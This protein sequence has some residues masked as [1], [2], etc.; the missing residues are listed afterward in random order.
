MKAIERLYQY[1]DNKNIKSTRFEKDLGMSNGYLGIM[2]KRDADLGS[3][4][5]ELIKN[6]CRD[7]NPEWLLT[8]KGNMLTEN[9]EATSAPVVAKS[10][11]KTGEES[12]P[13][14]NIDAVAGFG[15]GTFTLSEKDI[16][17]YYQVPDFNGIDF[18]VRVKGNSMY[19]KYS[20][21]DIIACRIIKE[22]GFIQ[23]NKPHLIATREQGLLVKRLRK[24]D[25]P[26][27]ILAVS[28]N[29][30]YEPFEIPQKEIT[31]I[32]IIIG[33]ISLE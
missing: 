6:N 7:L 18:M 22:S 19:P 20:S 13:L 4:V 26:D 27:C 25:T 15:N 14:I 17:A 1:F 9:K 12:I 24:C 32:A 2:R 29:T 21:G 33:V 3:S 30:H 10:E 31:G 5:L 11:I 8:G 23:W 28:D 16:Q